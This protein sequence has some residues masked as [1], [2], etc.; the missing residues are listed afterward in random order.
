MYIVRLVTVFAVG[1]LVSLAAF[2]EDTR[3]FDSLYSEFK[4]SYGSSKIDRD[5]LL[6]KL[7][8]IES[9]FT[10]EQNE[11]FQ[12][13]LA[14]SLGEKGKHE[15]RVALVESFI[16]QVR[17]PERRISFLYELVDGYAALGRYELALRSINESVLLLPGIENTKAKIIA[18]QGAINLLNSLRAVDEALDFA[19]RLH[20]LRGNPIDPY[21]EC[22]GLA[23]KVETNYMHGKHAVARGLVPAAVLACEAHKDQFLTLIVKSLVAIDLIDSGSHAQGIAAGLPLL[24]Q[25][26]VLGDESD[27]LAQLEEAIA[28]A[29]LKAGNTERAEYYGFKAYQLGQRSRTLVLQEKTSETMATI[30]R[31]QG[32][33][34]AAIGYYDINLDLKKKVLDDQLHRNLAYQRVKFDTQDK[35]NQLALLEQ[36]N[37]NLNTE[38]ELQQNKYQNL[39]LLLTLG[40]V[41]LAILG[42]WLFN[43]LRLKNVFRASAQVDGL[44]QVSNRAHFTACAHQIFKDTSRTVSLLLLDMDLFKKINDT[45]GHATGDWV[46][47]TVCETVKTQLHKADCFGRLGGE[48]FALCL[49]NVAE[50]DARALAERCRVAVAA[51]DTHPCGF[52][53][54]I[55]ASFGIATRGV[56]STTTFEETLVQADKALYVSKNEGRN[57]VTVYQQSSSTYQP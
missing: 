41:V 27:Y 40:L 13:A 26:S 18:L 3:T 20:A 21:L 43:T 33:L 9:T 8:A 22:L 39:I 12:M 46:L 52:D 2:A 24:Q 37:K 44:T 55:T 38:K 49:P 36:K 6:E 4:K 34:Q 17:T 14:H 30:K 28:R 10:P 42:A 54:P 35:T 15:E 5:G 7:K 45:Y 53:F 57:R 50:A 51:I 11:K 25:F 48:E 31:A 19:D 29:Y 47:K 16:N 23:N 1:L 32:Q 56:G